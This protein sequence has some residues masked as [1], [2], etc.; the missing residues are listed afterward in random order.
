MWKSSEKATALFA[1]VAISFLWMACANVAVDDAP[2]R[3][4]PEAGANTSHPAVNTDSAA[5]GSHVGTV[6][7]RVDG[8]PIRQHELD[9]WLKDDW[10]GS[11]EE[12]PAE[13]YNLRRAGIDGVIDDRLIDQAAANAERIESARPAGGNLPAKNGSTK[14]ETMVSKFS[15]PRRWVLP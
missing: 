2:P 9:Q 3:P 12:N 6:V 1:P 11:I 5:K 13:L 4:L 14:F 7:A 15:D 8:Q 10:L